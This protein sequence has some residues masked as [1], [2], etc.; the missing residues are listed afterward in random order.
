MIVNKNFLF[1]EINLPC[2]GNRPANAIVSD[3]QSFHSPSP[4]MGKS[5]NIER[6]PQLRK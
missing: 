2:E 4:K 3:H 6:I 1:R 5:K